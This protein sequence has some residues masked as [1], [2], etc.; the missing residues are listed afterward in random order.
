MQCHLLFIVGRIGLGLESW[1]IHDV[2][3][4]SLE[5]GYHNRHA[6][7]CDAYEHSNIW[8]HDNN[9]HHGNK[10]LEVASREVFHMV[11]ARNVLYRSR[12]AAACWAFCATFV[13]HWPG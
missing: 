6:S 2:P 9:W 7:G 5:H 11:I 4:Q 8:K 13:P 1:E 3:G 12:A 10:Q